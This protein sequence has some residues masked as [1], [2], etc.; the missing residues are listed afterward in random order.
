MRSPR[1][2][3]KRRAVW[4]HTVFR[5]GVSAIPTLSV[6]D[7]GMARILFLEPHRDV[8]ELFSQVAKRLGHDAVETVGAEQLDVVVLEPSSGRDVQRARGLLE[9][10]PALAIICAS[11]HPQSRETREQLDPVAYLVKPFPLAELERAL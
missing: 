5:P 9:R 7:P 6:E 10:F 11:I 3:A 2:R 8:R 4:T 1:P